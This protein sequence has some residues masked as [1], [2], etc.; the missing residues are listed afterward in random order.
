MCG[1]QTNPLR[2]RRTPSRSVHSSSVVVV[3]GSVV[4][5][6]DGAARGEVVVVS[7]PAVEQAARR[8]TRTPA[9]LR[10]GGSQARDGWPCNR[11]NPSSPAKHRHQ[12]P[13]VCVESVGGPVIELGRTRAYVPSATTVIP[14][15]ART[16]NTGDPPSVP[17]RV[18]CT[19][20]TQNRT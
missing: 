16:V 18:P 20:A 5:V 19:E 12:A 10:I 3:V 1:G 11:S 17:A 14:V 4:V 15:T 2:F 6:V 13:R 7:P 9:P 8:N